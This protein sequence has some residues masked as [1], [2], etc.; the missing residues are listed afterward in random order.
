[1]AQHPVFISYNSLDAHLALPVAEALKA[2]GINP[3]LDQWHLPPGR[4]WLKVV[5]TGL[6]ASDAVAVLIGPNG[7]GPVQEEEMAVAL[8]QA[9]RSGKPVIPVLLPGAAPLPLFLT[10]YGYV[11]LKDGP[12]GEG[13]GRLIWGIEA[14]KGKIAKRHP[15]PLEFTLRVQGDGTELTASWQQGSEQGEPFAL[16]LPLSKANLDETAWYLE[17]YLEFPGAGDRVRAQALEAKLHEWGL[18][19][20]QALFPGGEQNATYQK[21]RDHLDKNQGRVLLSLASENPSFLIRPWEMLRDKRGPLALRGLTLRRRLTSA[22]P[23]GGFPLERPLKVLLIVAR[24][25][26]TGFIDPR[27]STRPVLDALSGL[28]DQVKVD[29]CE[30]PTLP[31]LEQRLSIARRERAPY[32]IVHFDGH[33]QYY[34]ETGVG[35]L[36]FEDERQETKLIQGRDLGDLLSRL[37]VPLVLLEACRGAQVSDKPVFGA[38]APALLQSGVGSVVA[39]SHSV[40]V[41]AATKLCERLYRELVAGRS[42]GEALEEARAALHAHRARWLA[43]GP[44]PE[45][46]ELQDWIIPQ[47]YQAGGDPELVPAGDL[48]DAPRPQADIE[49]PGFPP[50]PRY[51][52]QGRARE[53]LKLERALRAHPAALLHAGGGMGKTALAREAAHWWRRTGRFPFALFHSFE[54]GAGAEA[55]VRRLGANLGSAAEKEAFLR[56]SSDEQWRRAVALF[57]AQPVL[58]VWD[59]YESVL[60][61]FASGGMDMASALDGPAR[62]DLERLYRELTAGQPRGRLLVTCRPA[63]TGLAGIQE[64]PLAGLARPDALHLLAAALKRKGISQDRYRRQS[65]EELLD[66]L[67]DHPLSIELVA[68]HLKDLSPETIIQDLARRLAQFHDDSPLEGR[69]RSLLAS[70]NFSRDRLDEESRAALDWL[71]WFEGGMF[72][73]FFLKF[74]QIPAPAWAVIRERLQATAL[75]RVEDLS[76]FNT[77]YLKL[78][79][80]LAEANPADWKDTEKAERFIGTYL[81][82]GAMIG[83]ALRGSR[84]AAGME[85]T[86]RELA[87]LRRAMALAFERGRH[88][89]GWALG[90][91]LRDYLE[92]AGRLRERDRLTA[93]VRENMPEDR[94][95]S[96]TCAAIRDHAW[97]LFTQGHAQE[98]LD[99]VRALQGRLEAGELADEPPARQLALARLVEGRILVHAGRPKWALGPLEQAITGLRE[100]GESQRGNLSAALG[101]KANALSA[102]GRYD[103]A[104]AAAEEGLALDRALGNDRSVAAGLGRTAAILMAAGRHGEAEARYG[105]ALKAAER[106]GDQE[107]QGSLLQHLGLLQRDTGRNGEAVATLKRAL[108][109]FQTSGDRGSEMRTC[110]LLASAEML[111]GRLDSAEAWYRKALALAEELHDERQIGAT[112]QNLGILYQKRAEALDDPQA[113]RP[114][115]NA[116]LAEIQASL[117]INQKMGNRLG[118]AASHFQLGILQRLLGDLDQAE[119]EVR[120]ALAIFESLGHPNA[121]KTYS[122]LAAI[123][124]DRGDAS[125]AAQWQAKADAK[126]EELERLAAG[127]EGASGQPVLNDQLTQALLQLARDVFQARVHGQPPEPDVA[128]ALAQLAGLPEPLTGFG[129]FLQALAAGQTPPPPAFPAP[130]QAIATALLDAL[131]R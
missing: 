20:W 113:R 15:A 79:P 3:W 107:L 129:R 36:C 96:A 31:E 87:N 99:A 39:F 118:E 34:P 56:L 94:L 29:F 21:I 47:L 91:T 116:A 14:G 22:P 86:S 51:G 81:G 16:T 26:G 103:E 24:P 9:R 32:H 60:P 52:F 40:H 92:R 120:Q 70:L 57:H 54:Q 44:D 121:R 53:L 11:D 7:L 131:R 98:A 89:D 42:I 38:V 111:L 105:E 109:L 67:E 76:Q 106:V 114:L 19:L 6:T 41:A 74:S 68:P 119:T 58:L 78:H 28:G 101:D 25:K 77:P 123:A 108:G 18:A 27:T 83:Q 82:V 33:G 65:L 5:E 46:V 13:L 43:L 49:L 48:G 125:A 23:V 1:M 62:A 55:V 35:A 61:A 30:P 64:V 128:E 12:A 124:R 2:R 126:R 37:Q 10:Q 102:L 66:R 88:R 50:E 75:L 104:L 97:T 69:N 84:P 122:V 130:L 63:A 85:L 4:P 73:A 95:D 80:T 127:P 93:W 110:D 90:D 59:N 45:T 17:R 112:R 8:E 117:A 100:L 72:E 115:L 71:G